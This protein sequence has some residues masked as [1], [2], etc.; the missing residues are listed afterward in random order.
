MSRGRRKRRLMVTRL[1]RYKEKGK[2]EK[3]SHTDHYFNV[4]LAWSMSSKRQQK[5]D[6]KDELTTHSKRIN[7]ENRFI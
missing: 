7:K 2:R 5:A 3:K 1:Y 6:N 4:D